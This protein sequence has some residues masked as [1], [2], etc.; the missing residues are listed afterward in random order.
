MAPHVFAIRRQALAA[1]LAFVAATAAQATPRH[2]ISMHGEPALPPDIVSLPQANADAPKGGTLVM[3]VTGSFDTLNPFITTGLPAAGISPL[4]VESLMGRSYDEPFTLYGLLAESVDTDDARSYVE[5]TLREEARFS[6][7]SPVTPADVLWSFETLGTIG[8]PRYLAA[9]AKVASAEQSGPRSVRFTFNEPDRELPLILGLRPVLEKAQ[10]E[11]R[12]FEAS[13]FEAPTGSG[14]YVVNEVQR[15]ASITFRRNPEWWGRDLP[16]NRGQWNFDTIRYDYFASSASM[17][18]AFKAGLVDVY[19]EGSAARWASAYDFP[20]VLSGEVVKSEIPHHRPSGIEGLTFNTRRPLF[21]DWRVREALILAF[22]FEFINRT[23]TGGAEPRI[24][25]YFSNSALG[26]EPGVPASGMERELLMPWKDSL[27]PGTLE[28]YALPVSDTPAA[29]RRNLRRAAALLIEAGW[30]PDAQ[31]VLRDATGTPFRFEILLT[32]GQDQMAA[33]SAIYVEELKALGIEAWMTIQ[34]SALVKTRTNAF[35]FDVTHFIRS[36]SLSPGNEQ[37]LY[38]G[39]AAAG[40]EGSR[41]WP[42]IESP[43]VDGLIA[44]LL[45]TDSPEVFT[46]AVRAL[47]RALVSGRYVIPIWYSDRS[48]IAHR[49]ELHFPAQLPLY[50]DWL[51]FLP[52]LWWYA[53]P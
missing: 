38:W 20:R 40:V 24:A 46:A 49:R 48:R 19:R 14:P 32:T 1:L 36:L 30:Q 34:D 47:D 11:G 25:S 4:V 33:L 39:S 50:G 17:F 7:G 9:W 42:G 53:D 18:E 28:G 41:N 26:M 31:G 27:L 15:G 6:D 43:A 13:G 45:A 10:W 51:G 35:D 37:L 16:F 2:A 3:G 21:A 12:D 44:T 8:N 23:L 5:F 29:Y 22:D 52:D